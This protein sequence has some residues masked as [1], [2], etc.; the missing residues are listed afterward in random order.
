[1]TVRQRL[2]RNLW[3]ARRHAAI[4]QAEVAR[5]ADLHESVV[6]LLETGKRLPRAD[7]LVKLA[8]ALQ[9]D[10]CDLLDG[11][12]WIP[13]PPNRTGRFCLQESPCR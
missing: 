11:I 8:A 10:P 13:G 6:S 9:I 3:L 1:M 5:R 12:E 2:G 7:T 4:T